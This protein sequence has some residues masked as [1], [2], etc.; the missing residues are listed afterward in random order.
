MDVSI[1]T[2]NTYEDVK[3]K[4]ITPARNGM[5]A[6][7]LWSTDASIH[8][9]KFYG[10]TLSING[11]VSLKG[12]GDPKIPIKICV[13]NIVCSDA[14]IETNSKVIIFADRLEGTLT[15]RNLN[16]REVGGTDDITD[17]P[18]VIPGVA[19]QGPSGGNGRH[20]NADHEAD[21]GGA[22]KPGGTGEQGTQGY[23]PSQINHGRHAMGVDLYIKSFAPNSVLD[24]MAQGG[25][26]GDGGKGG[27]GG[28]GQTGGTGGAGGNGGE[29]RW[30]FRQADHGGAGGTGGTGGVGGT[31]GTGG[32]AGNGGNGGDINIYLHDEGDLPRSWPLANEGGDP[33]KPGDGG[34]GGDGGDPGQGGE[35]G[36]GGDGSLWR[37]DGRLGKGGLP[38]HSGVAGKRG[39]K[40]AKG[41]KGHDG[42]TAY[43]QIG[44]ISIRHTAIFASQFAEEDFN[45]I[46]DEPM[47]SPFGFD[48]SPV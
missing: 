7:M 27:K 28:K 16:G 40:G 31:G 3:N 41:V 29:S 48:I 20:G 39:R 9:D 38:G 13:D 11:R 25:T 2:I 24:I 37:D 22:G 14:L 6:D 10:K 34:G 1:N 18:P 8:G 45:L 17:I 5:E 23:S 15:I 36:K 26:G 44:R 47:D 30:I 4:V 35:G 32:A 43:R 12:L 42:K 19:V 46:M 33:G 21:P